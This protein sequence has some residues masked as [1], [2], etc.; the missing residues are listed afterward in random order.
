MSWV[1]EQSNEMTSLVLAILEPTKPCLE[2]GTADLQMSQPP[3]TTR[4]VGADADNKGT[5]LGRLVMLPKSDDHFSIL[6]AGVTKSLEAAWKPANLG[7]YDLYA[8]CHTTDH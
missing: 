8:R 6:I 5:E 2:A 4:N 3:T 7:V 1:C